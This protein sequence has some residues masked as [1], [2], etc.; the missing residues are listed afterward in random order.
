VP[1]AAWVPVN[2]VAPGAVATPGGIET[3]LKMTE[4]LRIPEGT[5][6]PP[7]SALGFNADADD[8]A[9][10]AYFLSTDLARAITGTTLLVDAGYLLI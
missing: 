6:M 9:R 5:E 3:G 2:A 1:A 4:S 8:I 7:V 10:A